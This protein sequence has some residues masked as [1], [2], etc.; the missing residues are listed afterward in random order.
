MLT[1]APASRQIPAHVF[2]DLPIWGRP[3]YGPPTGQVAVGSDMLLQGMQAE[4]GDAEGG[5]HGSNMV[6]K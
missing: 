6:Q 1:V 5:E 3:P 4:T 2:S